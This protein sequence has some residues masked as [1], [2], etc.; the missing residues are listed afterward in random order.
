MTIYMLVI[1]FWGQSFEVIGDPFQNKAKCDYYAA[2]KNTFDKTKN[3]QE[4]KCVAFK[5]TK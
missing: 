2:Y 4:F 3:V 5:E 1:Y